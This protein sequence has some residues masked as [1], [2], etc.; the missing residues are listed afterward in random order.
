MEREENPSGYPFVE[1]FIKFLF[2][3]EL[4]FLFSSSSICGCKMVI[5]RNNFKWTD[6]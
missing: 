2:D 6:I 5:V 1:L 4:R 3:L